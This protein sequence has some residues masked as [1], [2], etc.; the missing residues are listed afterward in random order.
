MLSMEIGV[1]L[2]SNSYFFKGLK[3][4]THT[5]ALYHKLNRFEYRNWG[6]EKRDSLRTLASPHCFSIFNIL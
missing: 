2:S 1:L 4:K 3:V 6:L 5:S